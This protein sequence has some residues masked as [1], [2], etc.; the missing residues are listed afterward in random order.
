MFFFGAFGL[1]RRIGWAGGG[2]REQALT[3]TWDNCTIALINGRGV[4]P[5][6]NQK[7]GGREVGWV[8]MHGALIRYHGH[9]SA[10]GM[11]CIASVFLFFFLVF[12]FVFCFSNQQ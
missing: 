6:S 5:W 2:Y 8:V 12:F 11:A 3:G 1:A 7:M 4:Y 9:G 10:S